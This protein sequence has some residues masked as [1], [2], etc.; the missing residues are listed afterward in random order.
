MRASILVV[1][2]DEKERGELCAALERESYTT[3]PIH[4]LEFLESQLKE[5]GC[6]VVL[7]DLDTVPTDNRLFRGL[8]RNNPEV[9]IIAF[10]SRPFH[11]ELGEAM[12]SYIYASLYKPVDAHELIYWLRCICDNDSD[13]RDSL[14]A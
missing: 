9:R 6:Q 4:C 2:T 3:T 1:N 7:V 14:G 5:T 8:K 12:S 10:S 13:C 11:P